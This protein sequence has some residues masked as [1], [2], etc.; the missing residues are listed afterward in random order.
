M[1]IEVTAVGP[2]GLTGQEREALP[3][4]ERNRKWKATQDAHAGKVR[5]DADRLDATDAWGDPLETDTGDRGDRQAI[6]E[7]A[8]AVRAEN[9]ERYDRETGRA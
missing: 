4:A 9:L 7:Y 5:A 8:E 2:D 3:P 1:T 6:A